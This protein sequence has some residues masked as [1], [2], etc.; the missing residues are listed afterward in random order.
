[1]EEE[2]IETK[3]PIPLN[4][5][6]RVAVRGVKMAGSGIRPAMLTITVSVNLAVAAVPPAYPEPAEGPALSPVEGSADEGPSVSRPHLWACPEWSRGGPRSALQ[7]PQPYE[8][9]WN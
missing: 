4:A 1:M 2:A 6:L 3:S 5:I 7:D 8:E 9:R